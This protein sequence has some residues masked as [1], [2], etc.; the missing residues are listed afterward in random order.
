SRSRLHV[1]TS[2]V[3]ARPRV[4]SFAR[5]AAVGTDPLS[6]LSEPRRRPGQAEPSTE[7]RVQATGPA[8]SRR[9]HQSGRR[10]RRSLG[11]GP[12]GPRGTLDNPKGKLPYAGKDAA[13]EACAR[14]GAAAVPRRLRRAAGPGAFLPAWAALPRWRRRLQLPTP[15]P[16]RHR[17]LGQPVVRLRRSPRV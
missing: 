13:H 4:G 2:H 17:L 15:P 11:P 7:T 10:P 6:D 9:L 8:R 16:E 12:P 14:L 5:S 1:R 3:S